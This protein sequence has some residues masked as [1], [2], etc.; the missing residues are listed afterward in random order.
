METF[1]M[2]YNIQNV[3]QAR[4]I[5]APRQWPG[6]APK[7]SLRFTMLFNKHALTPMWHLSRLHNLC[8]QHSMQP[9]IVCRVC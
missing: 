9:I 3:Q 1:M 7:W 8:N 2:I 5:M 6:N 4:F